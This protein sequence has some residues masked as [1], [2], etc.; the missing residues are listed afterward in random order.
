[1]STF[2][3]LVAE[4]TRDAQR[5]QP[6]DALQ[7]CANW[8]QSRLEEQRTRTRSAL[9][10]RS[11]RSSFSHDIPVDHFLDTP[12]TDPGLGP[13]APTTVPPF[14]P[15]TS[16]AAI[17]ES[18]DESPFGTLN[19]QGNALLDDSMPQPNFTLGSAGGPSPHG[20][21]AP[22]AWD[23]FNHPGAHSPGDY[24]HPPSAMILARRTSVSAETIAVDQ[25]PDELPPVFAKT[26]AQ[27]ARIKASISNNFIF[28]DLD[29]EQERGVLDA[30][31]ET[32]VGA[33]E[34]VI[35]QGEQGEDFYVVEDGLLHCYIRP[36]PLPPSWQSED[37][38]RIK[39]D[40]APGEK[41]LQP[42]YH[43]V[44]GKKVAECRPGNSFGEL[45]LMY[46]HPR[47]ATVLSIEPC[48]LWSLDR[49]TF[50]TIILKA[51]HRRR[52]MYEQFLA[53]VP[54]LT[55]LEADERSKIADALV[56]RAYE[57][58]EAVVQQGEMGDTF[59]FVEEGEAAVTKLHNGDDGELEV[60][61]LRKGDYFGGEPP[62][63][64]AYARV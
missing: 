28:R 3:Q 49:I 39:R 64:C 13:I 53:S 48:T 16:L 31:K 45:A 15:R 30:M 29:E 24:L 5:V 38:S 19:V 52:T 36:E 17:H 2:D 63:L 32:R 27:L 9:A 46:G 54:L 55:G 23:G 60:G 22:P 35:R 47:A 42:G 6:K 57:D 51:A 59:F 33:D 18:I 7:F 37:A 21:P 25:G 44:F 62:S 10:H 34:I 50:R 56:S 14:A 4:L 58:G 11:S 40:A 8:F 1:M 61:I 43:P 20:T 26:E 12:M 41:F